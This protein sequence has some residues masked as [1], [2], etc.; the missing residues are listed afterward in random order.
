MPGADGGRTVEDGRVV[1]WRVGEVLLA[2]RLSDTVEIAAVA[3]DGLAV[4][5]SGRLEPRTPPGIAP[6]ER[7]VRAVVV[8]VGDGEVAMAADEVLG[9]EPFTPEDSASVPSW[10]G[11]LSAPHLARLV[12]LPDHR[13]AALLDLHALPEA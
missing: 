6:P 11:A 12:R 10:L 5:R 13:L 1:V 2:A 3:S 4:S 9:I 8:R 7:P